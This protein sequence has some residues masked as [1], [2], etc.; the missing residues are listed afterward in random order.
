MTL[1]SSIIDEIN[2]LARSGLEIMS[3]QLWKLSRAAY[4]V[5]GITADVYKDILSITVG[6]NE[7]SK[8][9][10]ICELQRLKEISG[11]VSQKWTQRYKNWD[12]VLNQLI[13]L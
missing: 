13:V 4:I 9:W 10:K 6:A 5:L 11:N 7:T 3:I 12:Q 1:L 2:G 8:F